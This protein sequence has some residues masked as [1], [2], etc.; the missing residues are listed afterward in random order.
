MLLQFITGGLRRCQLS[1]AANAGVV[2]DTWARQ[3][4]I[5]GEVVKG[6]GGY[7]DDE[8]PSSGYPFIQN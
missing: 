1:W 5:L 8:G 6:H 4:F 2:S 3:N 7:L